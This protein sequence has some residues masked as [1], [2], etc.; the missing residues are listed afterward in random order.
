M[1]LV[2]VC[3]DFYAICLANSFL[4]N[5]ISLLEFSVT[6]AIAAVS[7]YFRIQLLSLLPLLL[8]AICRFFEKC[9]KVSF[10]CAPNPIHIVS[11]KLQSNE[12]IKLSSLFAP[13]SF[14]FLYPFYGIVFVYMCDGICSCTTMRMTRGFFLECLCFVRHWTRLILNKTYVSF[15]LTEWA[16]SW[17]LCFEFKRYGLQVFAVF[18]LRWFS[19]SKY[20]KQ[21]L[22]CSTL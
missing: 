14:S 11:T 21:F 18:F 9:I 13:F 6:S 20:A 17:D 5:Y 12:L 7:P 22:I 8:F 15:S 19:I 3:W 4:I 10:F 2:Y 1:I 16:H